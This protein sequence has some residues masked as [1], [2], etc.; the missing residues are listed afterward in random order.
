MRLLI[1]RKK[2]RSHTSCGADCAMVNALHSTYLPKPGECFKAAEKRSS[3]LH[4][5]PRAAVP[6]S[7][8]PFILAIIP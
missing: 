3:D 4:I 2:H 5:L 8:Q 6:C 1:T 7:L